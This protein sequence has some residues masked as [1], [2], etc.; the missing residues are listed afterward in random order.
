LDVLISVDA[1]QQ[2]AQACEPFLRRDPRFRMQIQRSRLDWAGNTE[3]TM[4]QQRG[5][6]QQH[7]DR[8]SPT[9]VADLVEAAIRSPG[10]AVCFA[11]MDWSGDSNFTQFGF[12]LTGSPV[13]S[14]LAYLESLDTSPYRGLLRSSALARTSGLLLSDFDPFDSSGTEIRLLAELAIQG[15]FRFV[16]GPTYYKRIARTSTLSERTGPIDRGSWHGHA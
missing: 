3:W 8:V 15:D 10:A 9:H 6:F 7:D 4:R 12:S 11:K 5:D 14:A 1:S 13:K 2:S 16:P